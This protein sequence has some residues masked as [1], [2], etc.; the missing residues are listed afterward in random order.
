MKILNLLKCLI[1]LKQFDYRNMNTGLCRDC[2]D[3]IEEGDDATLDKYF[4][5]DLS[6][7]N[8]ILIEK[9]N[10]RLERK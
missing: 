2:Q 10:M 5:I 3:K 9:E 8:T 4:Q 7:I 6:E 1:C